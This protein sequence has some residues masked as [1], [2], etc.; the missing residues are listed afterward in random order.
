M[1]IVGA[2]MTTGKLSKWDGGAAARAALI[3]G[4]LLGRDCC[5]FPCAAIQKEEYGR[6]RINRVIT[7]MITANQKRRS[8]SWINPIAI[9][10]SAAQSISVQTT[11]P[12]RNIARWTASQSARMKPTRRLTSAPTA[13]PSRE[14]ADGRCLTARRTPERSDVL[15][16][17]YGVDRIARRGYTKRVDNL[18]WKP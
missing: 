14:N 18:S 2:A 17:F 4:R 6:K 8:F 11:A 16:V 3:R 12:A 15:L 5:C 7:G 9:R 1:N 13:N 10:Q